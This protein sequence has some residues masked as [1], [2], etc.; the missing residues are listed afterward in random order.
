MSFFKRNL[1]SKEKYTVG[2]MTK[3]CKRDYC[4]LR[5]LICHAVLF[6]CNKRYIK[7]NDVK[8]FEKSMFEMFMMKKRKKEAEINRL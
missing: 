2:R 6:G 7:Q 1:H 8:R 4:N 3:V 5:P